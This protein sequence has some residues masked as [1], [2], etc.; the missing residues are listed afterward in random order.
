MSKQS[1]QSMQ[2]KPRREYGAGSLRKHKGSKN[3]YIR[4]YLPDGRRIEEP[5]GTPVKQRALALLQKRLAER[6]LGVSPAQDLKKLTYESIRQ[7]L[8]DDYRMKGRRSLRNGRLAFGGLSHLDKF[9]AGKSVAVITSDTIRRFIA[10]RQADGAQAATIN[11]SLALLRRMLNLAR[12]E[13]KIQT[14][15]YFPALKENPPRKGFVTH[16]QFGRLLAALP[17]RLKPLIM[18]LY[19]TG[20]RVG[21]ARKIEWP[22]I[23]LNQRQIVMLGEQTK[24]GQPRILPLPDELVATLE[25]VL[26]PNRR[27]RVFYQGSFRRSWARACEQAGLGHR[28]KTSNGFPKYE[29]L[30]VHDLR[31]SAVRNLREA[32]VAETIIM[33]ISGHRTTEVFRR[34]S[35][36]SSEDLCRAMKQLEASLRVIDIQGAPATALPTASNGG[37]SGVGVETTIASLENGGKMGEVSEPISR[38]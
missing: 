22:Q 24:S 10:A 23:D 16:E 36:M 8:L 27:G 28:I 21:E 33:A 12:I 20:V 1:K 26:E 34:Y 38:K 37:S 13:G 25:T 19:W 5:T 11:R 32:G 2:R 35:I 15:P 18:L 30:L 3:W 6:E 9:F 31:R 14:V 7:S 4:Y 29:G 17:E